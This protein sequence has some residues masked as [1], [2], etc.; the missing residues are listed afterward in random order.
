VKKGKRIGLWGVNWPAMGR[1]GGRP[2]S[3]DPG[4]EPSS[5]PNP[6]GAALR[7]VIHPGELVV[8]PWFS[9]AAVQTAVDALA[10]GAVVVMRG[11]EAA[12]AIEYPDLAAVA[13]FILFFR[14]GE[15]LVELV[16]VSGVEGATAALSA[17]ARACK[18]PVAPDDARR[19]V[20]KEHT[21]AARLERIAQWIRERQR[22]SAIRCAGRDGQVEKTTRNSWEK[23]ACGRS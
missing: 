15:E 17:N 6:V 10:S 2:R 13:C 8:L 20:L 21:V 23:P 14:T 16:N 9:A 11:C 7:G 12:F 4:V 18:L 19:L 5:G 1:G 22:T 3:P